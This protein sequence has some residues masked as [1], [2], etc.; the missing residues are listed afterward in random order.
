MINPSKP[1]LGFLV[2]L[3]SALPSMKARGLYKNLISHLHRHYIFKKLTI[4][5]FL[6]IPAGTFRY[7]S[8]DIYF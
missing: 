6:V 8:W 5:F 3:E 4:I 1:N 2:Y 7:V